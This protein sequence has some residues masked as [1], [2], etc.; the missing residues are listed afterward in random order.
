MVDGTFAKNPAMARAIPGLRHRYDRRLLDD[1]ESV[2]LSNP[3]SFSRC[4]EPFDDGVA[5][6]AGFSIALL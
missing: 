1:R 4:A 2:R 6:V 5:K 3:L